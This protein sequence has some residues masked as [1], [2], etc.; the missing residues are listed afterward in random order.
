MDVYTALDS[1]RAI[2]GDRVTNV[3]SNGPELFKRGQ[4]H[5]QSARAAL[6]SPPEGVDYHGRP[7]DFSDAVRAN[8]EYAIASAAVASACFAGAQAAAMATLGA[9]DANDDKLADEWR[10]IAGDKT[11]GELAA[12]RNR[13]VAEADDAAAQAAEDETVGA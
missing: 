7:D 9:E 11:D 13:V 6:E 12:E 1:R 10:R 4:E 3:I 5:L 8:N 2:E